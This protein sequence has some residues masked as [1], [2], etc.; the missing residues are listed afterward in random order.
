VKNTQRHLHTCIKPAANF[1]HST[2]AL[3]M[4]QWQ[5][6]GWIRSWPPTTAQ[7]QG[8]TTAAAVRALQTNHAWLAPCTAR[9]FNGV[10]K[11]VPV[12]EWIGGITSGLCKLESRQNYSIDNFV[13]HL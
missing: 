3:Q 12:Y 9:T 10:L 13:K 6:E 5:W 7:W 11:R 4:N 8:Q 1:I 2:D